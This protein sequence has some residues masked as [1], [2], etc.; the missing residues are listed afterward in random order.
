ML[1]PRNIARLDRLVR[2]LKAGILFARTARPLPPAAR[3]DRPGDWRMTTSAGTAC[4]VYEPSR[5]QKTFIAVHGVTATGERDPRLVRLSRLLA[6]SGIRVAAVELPG[7]KSL[8]FSDADL[9]AFHDLATALSARFGG[10]VGV[11][12]F[13]FGGGVALAAA[14]GLHAGCVDPIILFGAYHSLPD[15]LRHLDGVFEKLPRDDVWWDDFVY[16]R[17]IRAIQSADAV[18][19][20]DG[21]RSEILTF[22]AS[23]C[24]E[25][26]VAAKRRFFD[27]VLGNLPIPGGH[28]FDPASLERLSPA[29]R[30]GSLA[31]RVVLL[32][33]SSDRIIPPVH[34][35]RIFAELR[36]RRAGSQELLITP[37]L[38]HVNPGNIHRLRDLLRFM[39]L[40]GEIYRWL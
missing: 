7:L 27:R 28:D 32:H 5:P 20:D 22:L 13:S 15:V 29:G 11:I 25:P 10:P 21:I 26:S 6:G 39:S 9:H 17:A 33:D 8:R 3:R 40:A 16:I 38:S 19:L 12:A 2:G 35:E 31:C 23:Y 30:L 18:G 34:S 37:V 4:D 36:G 14:A 1:N 24:C